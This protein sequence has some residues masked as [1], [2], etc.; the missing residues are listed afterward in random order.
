MFDLKNAADPPA[1]HP[2]PNN[3]RLP[4]NRDE[5]LVRVR[6]G[7]KPHFL[8]QS[9]VKESDTTTLAV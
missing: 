7:V 1:L 2:H 5:N 9:A 8:N 4:P 3:Q 6:G